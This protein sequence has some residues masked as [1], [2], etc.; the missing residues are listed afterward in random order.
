MFSRSFCILFLIGGLIVAATF[1]VGLVWGVGT[2]ESWWISN[3]FHFVGGG[4]AVF[5]VRELFGLAKMRYEIIV[6]RWLQMAIFIGG[7]IVL[8]VFW[9]WFEFAI[10]RYTVLVIGKDSIMSY[11][12]NIGDLIIDFF[13]ATVAG[14]YLWKSKR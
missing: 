5:F 12:D 10:D 14:V 4:Y 9:E 6:P 2:W 7:A 3:V 1:M 8:G 13:G 11:A